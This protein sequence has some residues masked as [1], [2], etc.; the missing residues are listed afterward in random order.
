MYG[1]I[2]RAIRDCV[3]GEYGTDTWSRI[4]ERAGVD[5]SAFTSMQAYPDEVTVGL[6]V[7][8]AEEVEED[9]PKLLHQ[10]GRFWVLHTARMEYGPLF[11]FA[12]SDMQSFLENLNAMHEQVAITFANLQQPSFT[13][14]KIEDGNLLLHYESI[15]DG[16]S[17]FVIGLIEG[18][19]EHFKEPTQVEQVEAK[20]EGAD[21]DVFKLIFSS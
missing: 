8:T 19:S 5:E 17:A 18:L 1:L 12:G 10:F 11:D 13:V 16:L 21:H 7:S 4:Q 2:H 9:L 20:A 15:R 3:S 6:L 14:E